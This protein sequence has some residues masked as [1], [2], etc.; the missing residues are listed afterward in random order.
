MATSANLPPRMR[1]K[2]DQIRTAAQALFLRD[3]F[4]G[5]TMDAIAAAAG[6]S[7]QTLYHY[8]QSKEDLFVDIL[9]QL[10]LERTRGFVLDA[11]GETGLNSHEEL[12]AALTQ[13]AQRMLLTLMQPT[14]I[15]LIR[16]IVAETA[17]FPHLAPLFRAAVP[18]RGM[19]ILMM[20]LERARA[21]GLIAA[22]DPEVMAR[23]FAGPL[24]TYVITDGLGAPN[25]TPQLPPPERVAMLVR[26]FIRAIT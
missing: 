3:G 2:R 8:Y 17:R 13:L 24:L 20:L 4:A 14:Y 19:A 11:V 15:A 12:E 26:L 5:A 25:T 18:E 21:Q 9:Q 6:V 1:A 23:L 10:T 22:H 7:K 16:V